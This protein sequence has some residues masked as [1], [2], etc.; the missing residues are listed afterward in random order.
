M[1]IFFENIYSAFL[2]S[3]SWDE[4]TRKRAKQINTSTYF[5]LKD[6]IEKGDSNCHKKLKQNYCLQ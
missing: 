1:K 3:K 4:I 2:I 6:D 5:L